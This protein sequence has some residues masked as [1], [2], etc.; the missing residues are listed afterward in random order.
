ML[1]KAPLMILS[2]LM[3]HGWHV[4]AKQKYRGALSF[5]VLDKRAIITHSIDE[6]L[7]LRVRRA[8]S[9]SQEYFGW[10]VEAVRRPVKANSPDLLSPGRGWHGPY[11][12]EVLAWHVGAHLFRDERELKVRGYPY[13]VRIALIDPV[14]AG[15]DSDRRFVS[16]RIRVSWRRKYSAARRRTR[17]WSGR[18]ISKHPTE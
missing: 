14:V 16:G 11:P 12:S 13:V 3:L 1:M 2:A 15:E 6:H 9:V 18:A 7:L 5:S 8:R 17:R 10:Q 4:E